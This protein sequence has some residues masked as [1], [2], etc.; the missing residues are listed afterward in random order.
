MVLT[1]DIGNTSTKI[2][3]F[4]A[5]EFSLISDRYIPIYNNACA[6]RARVDARKGRHDVDWQTLLR[7]FGPDKCE[8][9]LISDVGGADPERDKLLDSCSIP[10][11]RLTWKSPEYLRYV[12]NTYEGLGADRVAVIIAA[13]HQAPDRDLL[14]IDAGTCITYDVVHSDGNHVGGSI[15]P[16]VSLRLRAMHDYTAALPLVSHVGECPVVGFD[17]ETALRGGVVNGVRWEMEG[18]MR[19]LLAE[20]PSLKVFTT[21]GNAFDFSADLAQY[22]TSDRLLV[23]R[24]LVFAFG[25][26]S[27]K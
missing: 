2:A 6:R 5:G 14:I 25:F 18:Y 13:R 20:H 15:T 11:L 26:E 17:T 8:A 12:A 4:A 1:I 16:G 23:M 27:T 19:A 3:T 21:G 22:I 10:V 24:G 9:I 7:D